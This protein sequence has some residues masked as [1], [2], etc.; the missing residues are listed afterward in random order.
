MS[1]FCVQTDFTFIAVITENN[2]IN[3]KAM[4][5]FETTP[6]LSIVYRHPMDSSRP[7]FFILDAVHILKCIRNNWIN[8]KTSGTSIRFPPFCFN[9]ISCKNSPSTASFESLQLLHSLECDLLIKFAYKLSWKALHPFTLKRQNVT[10]AL[11][12]FNSYVVQALLLLGEKNNIPHYADTSSFIKIINTWRSIV[13]VKT[14][15]RG[16]R[17]LNIFEE[18]LRKDDHKSKQFLYYFLDWLASWNSTSIG[19]GKLT[20]ETFTALQHS[21][22]ALLELSSYCL[23]ELGAKY[24][25]LGKFQTDSLEARFGQ[26]RQLSVASTTF[27]SDKCTK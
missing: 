8:Q 20:R 16:K 26:Y 12:V 11:Q 15:M 2:A 14:P 3:R 9:D 21:T 18:P 19:A 25:L 22:H 23:H 10:Y 1:F 17:L 27:Q 13:N 7:L 24:V 6:K 4:A 5:L